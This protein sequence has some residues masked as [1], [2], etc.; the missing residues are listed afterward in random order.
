M[1]HSRELTLF[2]WSI[3]R[4]GDITASGVRSIQMKVCIFTSF[5]YLHLSSEIGNL[6]GC[7]EREGDWDTSSALDLFC[8]R[9]SRSSTLCIVWAERDAKVEWPTEIHQQIFFEI[10]FISSERDRMHIT[11]LSLM[12]PISAS[13]DCRTLKNKLHQTGNN[14]N[15]MAFHS[16]ELCTR[17]VSPIHLPLFRKASKARNSTCEAS[18]GQSGGRPQR[19]AW[20]GAL[21]WKLTLGC[22]R[23]QTG[24]DPT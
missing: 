7:R 5:T 12:T 3:P 9:Q 18:S 2:L 6:R 1:Q 23:K 15:A 24:A 16:I 4:K 21:S 10:A 22:W 11:T 13:A 19:Q 17:P 20:R 8:V 14:L